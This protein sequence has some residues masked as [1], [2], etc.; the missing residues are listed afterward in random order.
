VILERQVAHATAGAAG[1][2]GAFD[3]TFWWCLGFTA[4]ALVPAL[5]LAGRPA[6]AQ[7]AAPA[8]ASPVVPSRS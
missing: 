8:Q 2:A 6:A 7:S 5:L 4:L 3:A 1:L